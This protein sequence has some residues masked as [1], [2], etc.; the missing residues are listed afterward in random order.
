MHILRHITDLQEISSKNHDPIF[1][2]IKMS[3]A[4]VAWESK[5][6]YRGILVARD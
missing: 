6:L 3:V 4:E 2:H 1:S 5:S